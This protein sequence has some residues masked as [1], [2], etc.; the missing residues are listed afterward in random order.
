M[1]DFIKAFAHAHCARLITALEEN[2]SAGVFG[3]HEGQKPFVAAALSGQLVITRYEKD[4]AAWRQALC[5][6][7][8]RAV[9]IIPPQSLVSGAEAETRALD[10][11]R[12]EALWDLAE[13]G[14]AVACVEAALA[15]LPPPTFLKS[16]RHTLE[17]SQ[18]LPPEELAERLVRAGYEHTSQAESPG[19]F[20]RRGGILDCVT[21]EGGIRISWFGDE[22][23]SIRTYDPATQ[24]MIEVVQSVVIPPA[25]MGEGEGEGLS[26]TVADYLPD[27]A[28]VIIDEPVSL[29]E[30][31]EYLY[32]QA[33]ELYT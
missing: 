21:P 31:A 12:A 18:V 7:T 1:T 10:G 2:H 30:T 5:A 22:I 19:Q 25:G 20:A 29:A 4:A 3:V 23:D 17:I 13:G 11:R 6:L 28:V 16:T 26:A 27:N 8:G 24:R 33:L 14:V 15:A 9:S 32:T